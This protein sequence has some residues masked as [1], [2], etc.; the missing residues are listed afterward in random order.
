M[1]SGCKSLKEIEI[2]SSVTSIAENA[3]I[4]CISLAGKLKGFD[5]SEKPKNQGTAL[6]WSTLD[7]ISTG[8]SWNTER[9]E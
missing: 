4:G 5:T 7:S 2:P 6:Q 8:N 3:F 9:N 1:L